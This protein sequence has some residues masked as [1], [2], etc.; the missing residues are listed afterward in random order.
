VIP[1]ARD[2]REAVGEFA[3]EVSNRSLLY[4]K[5]AMPKTYGHKSHPSRKFDD[6][7]RLSVIRATSNSGGIF[8]RIIED[9]ERTMWGKGK[10]EN[11]E[12][13]EYLLRAA[14]AL[15]QPWQDDA[16]LQQAQ[17]ENTERLLI[18]LGRSYGDRVSTF[19]AALGG[20]L[21]INAAG[22]VM[23][24]AGIAL[25][26]CFGNPMIPGSAI[27]GVTRS[28]ALW[29]IRGLEGD[30][31]EQALRTAIFA[32]GYGPAHRQDFVFA[33]GG[34]E[35]L[36]ARCLDSV[37]G[38]EFR[39]LC[40]FLP[41]TPAGPVS[42]VADILTPHHTGRLIPHCFPVV[43][44]GS[45]FGFAVLVQ[46]EDP[47]IDTTELLTVVR[48]WME[49]AITQGGVGGKTG[50]G[51][52][53]FEIDPEA[54]AKRQQVIAEKEE[55]LVAK[56]AEEAEAA[57]LAKVEDER[58]AQLS[59]VD[60]RAEEIAGLPDHEFAEIAKNLGSLEDK[61]EQLAFL[62]V[63]ASSAKKDR[64]KTWNKK[65]PDLFESIC[66]VAQDLGV[67]LT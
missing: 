13:A 1:L 24:N 28:H 60:R 56:L 18:D 2:V 6:A 29:K 5:M 32:F 7:Q 66:A 9:S 46:R 34:D 33:A 62:Q 38:G 48:G 51:Y 31:K 25:D 55:R 4:E 21:I 19:V 67:T 10:P 43:E 35:T 20:R 27:K 59:P 22:G 47:S 65:K 53:W 50:A 16:Q 36:V 17:I 61:N 41:A 15:R 23:Q 37:G 3:T 14:Q 39:G 54:D 8:S 44:E 11:K 64:R 26:R 40:S 45:E 49:G 63:L 58:L 52:G 57:E 42:V 12:K 30:K